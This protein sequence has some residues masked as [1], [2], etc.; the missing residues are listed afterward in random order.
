MGITSPSSQLDIKR[1]LPIQMAESFF[2]MPPRQRDRPAFVRHPNPN[3]PVKIPQKH[4]LQAAFLAAACAVLTPPAL[5]TDGYFVQGFG[6][7]NSSLGGAA[8]AGNDQDLIGSIYKNPATAVMFADRTASIVFGD[9]IP[10]VRIDSSVA[11]LGLNG[12]SNSTIN[13]VPYLSLMA[14][15][16]GSTPDTAWF[17]GAVSEAG[18]SFHAATSA[19]NP[20][21]FSQAGAAGNPYGGQFGGFGDVRSSLYVVRFPLGLAGT[22]PGGWSW[23][24]ALAPSIGRNLFTP[25]AFAPPALGTNGHPA[26][27]TVQQ[28]DM[29]LGMG[30]QGGLRWQAD[31]DLSVG[32][33][34]SSPTWFHTYSWDVSV[35]TG[36]SRTVTFRMDRPLTAQIGINYA[37]AESTHLLAD[38]GYIAYGSTNGFD[39][40]GF[41]AD[42]SIAGLGW[43]DSYTL[44]VGIQHKLTSNIIVRVGYNYCSDPI[45]DNMTFY[46]VGS[47]LHLAQH[48]S[49]GTSIIM[50]PGVTLDLSFT[51]GLSHTQS[52]SW[53]TPYGAVPGTSL[54]SEISGNEFAVGTTFRF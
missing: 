7:V 39:N 40:S 23:G 9:I 27:A 13:G 16:K 17:A 51:R 41:R 50:S 8:T 45:P 2:L 12:T 54:T 30:A 46:N 49:I 1:T 25:A 24:F 44:E 43:N 20:I 52:S 19:T 5:A 42:G 32:I 18:L 6:A 10:S 11:G 4:L 14:S 26:Y 28:Q 37:I 53:Y 33:S 21:F 34:L 35:P 38:V 3:N 22:S 15:W 48:I 47:P 29:Q 31:K 36:G